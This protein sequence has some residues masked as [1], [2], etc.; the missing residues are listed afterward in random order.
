MRAMVCARPRERNRGR[1]P[2]RV[3][4][5]REARR[6]APNTIETVYNYID[7]IDSYYIEIRISL[8]H[9]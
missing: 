5:R 7:I 8:T 6:P 1:G 3:S 2:I 4:A 9:E